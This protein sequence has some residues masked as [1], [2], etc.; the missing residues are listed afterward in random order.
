MAVKMPPYPA[1]DT[2]DRSTFIPVP[3][4]MIPPPGLA[5]DNVVVQF[6]YGENGDAG[7]IL[8][9]GQAGEMPGDGSHGAG[10][11]VRVSRRKARAA[12]RRVS[13]D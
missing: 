11:S 10:D 1:T 3:V 9:H 6:G 8:L 13:R 5:V 7:G 4:K 12:W 2:V